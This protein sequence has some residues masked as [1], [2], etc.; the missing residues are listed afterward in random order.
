[1]MRV[2]AAWTRHGDLRGASAFG[3]ALAGSAAPLS[4]GFAPL[5]ASAAPLSAGFAPLAGSAAPLSVGFAPAAAGALFADLLAAA[6]SS[7]GGGSS[8]GLPRS[9]EA[10]S[11]SRLRSS[12]DGLTADTG[13]SPDSAT[14]T[15]LKIPGESPVAMIVSNAAI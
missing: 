14:H 2:R 3:S 9:C 8:G 7:G 11:I 5:A 13:T 12:S 1:N 15:P 6:L 4:A 10:R